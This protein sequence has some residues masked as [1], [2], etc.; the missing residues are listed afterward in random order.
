MKASRQLCLCYEYNALSGKKQIRT[1]HWQ[2]TDRG[3]AVQYNNCM[4]R[5]VFFYSLVLLMC[6]LSGCSHTPADYGGS[7]TDDGSSVASGMFTVTLT[8]IDQRPSAS[9]PVVLYSSAAGDLPPFK[10]MVVATENCSGTVIW[11][12]RITG[13]TQK[14]AVR[15]INISLVKDMPWETDLPAE[16]YASYVGKNEFFCVAMFTDNESFESKTSPLFRFDATL[17]ESG[18]PLLTVTCGNGNAVSNKTDWISGSVTLQFPDG[19]PYDDVSQTVHIK[20]R[21]NATW[22][23][24]KKGYS[25]KFSE[26]TAVSG[27]SSHK[28]WVLV[29]NYL[30]R[31]LLRNQFIS[32]VGKTVFTGMSWTPSFVPVDF[33]LNNEYLGTYLIGEQIKIDEH[34][35][36][37]GEGSF[38]V[39][40]NCRMD[41]AFNFKTSLTDVPVSLKDPDDVPPE[42]QQTVREIIN[43][44]ESVLFSDGYADSETGY[45]ACLDVPSFVDWYLLNELAKT[46]DALF[47]AENSSS[48]YM[49]YDSADDKLH[50]GPIWDYDV[51]CGLADI[52]TCASPEGFYIKD[53]EGSSWFSRLL[54]DDAFLQAVKARWEEVR[55]GL[56]AAI[57]AEIDAEKAVIEQS[58][59][60][61]FARWPVLGTK[62]IWQ[63]DADWQSRTTFESE[64]QHLK[65]WLTARWLWMDSAIRGL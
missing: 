10:V 3:A 56:K 49:Y 13:T 58:A 31:S 14:H 25:L 52:D 47:P 6:I 27:M 60:M 39:E 33:V 41:E 1:K 51:A 9:S 26:K 4:R 57:D 61:N 28:K 42:M 18:L 55:E 19:A 24:P 17:P 22:L 63:P 53:A 5:L 45:A 21:G 62:P 32:Y 15:T 37:V 38:I 11:Y 16:I 2:I 43:R 12:H 7:E 50:M 8:P 23:Y 65:D 40:I 44:T 20:G 35:V 46:R 48:V 30:D 64:V 34:R 36:N 54:S 59:Q 29:G